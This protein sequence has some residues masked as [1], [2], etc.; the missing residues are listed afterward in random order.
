MRHFF[1]LLIAISILS[2]CGRDEEPTPTPVPTLA[3]TP[4]PTLAPEPTTYPSTAFMDW[5]ATNEFEF[6]QDVPDG[7]KRFTR[8]ADPNAVAVDIYPDGIAAWGMTV[9][10]NAATVVLSETTNI[11]LKAIEL[12]GH[13][14]K[15][16]QDALQ[17]PYE[18]PLTLQEGDYTFLLERTALGVNSRATFLEP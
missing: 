18:L 6:R 3:P 13:D 2:A 11:V 9:D 7:S 14:P 5:L 15:P 17:A 16:V 12:H 10:N 4:A 1:I 8:S